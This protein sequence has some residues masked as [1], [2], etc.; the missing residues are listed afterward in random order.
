ME[1]RWRGLFFWGEKHIM[2]LFGGQLVLYKFKKRIEA[3]P[4]LQFLAQLP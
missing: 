1:T 3:V 2:K 4:K